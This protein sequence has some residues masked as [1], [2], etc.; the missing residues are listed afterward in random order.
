[1]IGRDS[2]DRCLRI[3]GFLSMV[4]DHIGYMIIW[5]LYDRACVV[6]DVI[7]MG[8]I[9]PLKARQL[10]LAYK[11][12][13]LIGRLALPIYSYGIVRG[14]HFTTSRIRYLSRLIVLAIISEIPYDLAMS[15]KLFDFEGQNVIWT[16][17]L[18]LSFICCANYVK[19]N[20]RRIKYQVIYC[21]CLLITAILSIWLRAEGSVLAILLIFFFE[22]FY[23]RRSFFFWIIMTTLFVLSS[24]KIS[25]E[26]FGI[27]GVVM[28]KSTERNIRTNKISK[29]ETLI[30]Y[31]A[32]P[33]H[34]LLL[35]VISK[36]MLLI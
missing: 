19:C 10:Y 5:P 26:L 1:M 24:C 16:W 35:C 25:F 2:I 6:N 14:F 33:V 36:K 30:S 34:F 17:V 8:D 13:R 22:I 28:V 21:S 32:Y 7:M 23:Y 27:V 15:S 29:L 9:V 11:M 12:T 18:G 31:A 3:V 4:I 20:V